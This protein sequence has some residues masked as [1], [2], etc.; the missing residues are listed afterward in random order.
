VQRLDSKAPDVTWLV[1]QHC[2]E[3]TLYSIAYYTALAE[4]IS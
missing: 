2:A 1:R 3:L 4:P